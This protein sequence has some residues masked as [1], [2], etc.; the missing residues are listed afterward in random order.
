MH[1]LWA[2][3][4][5][6]RCVVGLDLVSKAK[7]SNMRSKRKT[8]DMKMVSEQAHMEHAEHTA[9]IEQ[10]NGDLHRLNPG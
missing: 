9:L 7:A 10:L 3:E 1:D 6:E 2:F 8:A 4:N 5:P